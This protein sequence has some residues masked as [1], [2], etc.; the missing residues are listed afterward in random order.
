MANTA[1]PETRVFT[2]V[3][4]VTR[5]HHFPFT[6]PFCPGNCLSWVPSV[7]FHSLSRAIPVFFIMTSGCI[8]EKWFPLILSTT[9]PN[10]RSTLLEGSGL[11]WGL[12]GMR[13]EG[14]WLKTTVPNFRSSTLLEGSGLPRGLRGMRTEGAGWRS[15]EVLSQSSADKLHCTGALDSV[16][17]PSSPRLTPHRSCR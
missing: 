9:V 6:V 7:S 14:C 5:H 4:Y 3:L 1:V 10:F 2:G 12:R 17:G 16:G 13:T 11:P 15:S 8:F